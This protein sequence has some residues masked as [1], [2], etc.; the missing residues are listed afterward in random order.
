MQQFIDGFMFTAGGIVSF[1]CVFAVAELCQFLSKL[2]SEFGRSEIRNA[3]V[4][5]AEAI[6]GLSAKMEK[7]R[8]E[9]LLELESMKSKRR[10]V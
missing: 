9:R 1:L 7:T 5:N 4:D 2:T 8:L 3:I 10:P 6:C